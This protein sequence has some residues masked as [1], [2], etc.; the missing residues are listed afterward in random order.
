[1]LSLHDALPISSTR[2][3]PVT[4]ARSWRTT[5][6]RCARRS[7]SIR[8]ASCSTPP[9]TPTCSDGRCRR[10]CVSCRR[11]RP[12]SAARSSG[13]PAPRRSASRRSRWVRDP[14]EGIPP[15]A[16][17][18]R[19]SGAGFLRTTEVRAYPG[20][21]RL[22]SRAGACVAILALDSCA[23]GPAPPAAKLWT[24]FDVDALYAAGAPSTKALAVGD[25]FPGGVPLGGI[26]DPPVPPAGPTLVPHT[27]T[28]DG[29]LVNYVT[30]EV[31]SDYA[32]VWMQPVYVPITGVV[33]GVPH[34]V[35]DEM[36]AWHPIFSV[37]PASGFYSPYWQITYVTVPAGTTSSTFTSAK[38]IL[39]SGYPLLPTEGQTMPLVP[40]QTSG[41]GLAK[42]GCG[43]L[44]GA[45][46]GAAGRDAT[47]GDVGGRDRALLGVLADVHGGPAAAAGPHLRAAGQRG[48]GRSPGSQ[49]LCGGVHGRARRRP[50]RL[51]AVHRAGGRQPRRSEHRH[52]GLLRRSGRHR[53]GLRLARFS[54][55]AGGER[56]SL[57]DPGHGDQRDLP[58]DHG[59]DDP[60][61]SPVTARVL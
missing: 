21:V 23:P 8:T 32:Q 60:G 14:G 51:H 52:T 48:R 18:A 41:G 29:Y 3:S 30:T 26:V 19:R 16:A 57:D 9:T 53:R 34:K 20:P 12:A 15:L 4:T 59:E 38:Q 25:G 46:N 47:G 56:R 54:S 31:W 6:W 13:S 7:S 36:G 10:R 42:A 22:L 61:E 58:G 35:V 50:R 49:P 33:N 17:P 55:G 2:R 5:G 43:W 40:D 28:A 11:C 45:G 39:D 1:T 27:G 37:G 44:D 24:L